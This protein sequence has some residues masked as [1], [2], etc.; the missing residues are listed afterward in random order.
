MAKNKMRFQRVAA[1]HHSIPPDDGLDFLDAVSAGDTDTVDI[2][3]SKYGEEGLE[4]RARDWLTGE[5][6]GDSRTGIM[7]AVQKENTE[8]VE[9][10]IHHGADVAAKTHD[11]FPVLMLSPGPEMSAL[12]LDNGAQIECTNNFGS[13]PLMAARTPALLTF[14]LSRD[15]IV[16]A[17]D[18]E[19]HTAL[20][21]LAGSV[22]AFHGSAVK[23]LEILINGGAE[24]DACNNEGKTA[25]MGAAI[26][27]VRSEAAFAAARY[28]LERGASPD[29]RDA[30]GR[31]AADHVRV[32]LAA[33]R[34]RLAEEK[35]ELPEEPAIVALL[36][37]ASADHAEKSRKAF[38]E[39]AE[40]GVGVMK[41][42]QLKRS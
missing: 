37:Q 23:G 22:H 5:Q 21:R 15:A 33:E 1:R 29:V 38:T 6:N 13:T 39:G 35:S 30:A 40:Q 25:L 36:A 7:I 2:Y 17:R 10:L 34:A 3:V 12:L 32:A 4:V 27:A 14:L 31:S 24:I 42:L 11:G 28:L 20:I 16:D 41:P 9:T 8:M 19:G 18:K 26:S